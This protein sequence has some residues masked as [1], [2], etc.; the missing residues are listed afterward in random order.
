MALYSEVAT[1]GRVQGLY[2]VLEIELGSKSCKA[3]ILYP[4]YLSS[5]K[6]S[7]FFEWNG[8]GV[9]QLTPG[10]AFDF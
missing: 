10:S 5:P 6:L 4:V 3:R 1:L 8:V 7:I 9:G 2:G